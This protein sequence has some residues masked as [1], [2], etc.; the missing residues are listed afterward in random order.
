LAGNMYCDGMAV[1]EHL[2]VYM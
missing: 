1:N 2:S